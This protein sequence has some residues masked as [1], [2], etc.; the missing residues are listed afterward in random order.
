M[1]KFGFIDI[2]NH[3]YRDY[4]NYHSY[5]HDY[6]DYQAAGDADSD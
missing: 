2:C 3:D 1:I 4:Q 6:Q 5:S